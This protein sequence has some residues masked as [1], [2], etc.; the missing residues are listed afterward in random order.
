MAEVQNKIDSTPIYIEVRNPQE[1][2]EGHVD[3]EVCCLV[4]ERTSSLEEK[5]VMWSVRRR[6]N[7]FTELDK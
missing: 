2:P 4:K 7:E 5:R 3:Y 6:Y 1:A